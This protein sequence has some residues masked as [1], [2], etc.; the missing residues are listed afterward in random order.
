M[1]NN[2]VTELNHLTHKLYRKSIE[3]E[4]IDKVGPSHNPKIK[5][6]ISFPW[7]QIAFVGKGNNKHDAKQKAAKKALKYLK[8][9]GHE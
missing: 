5:M 1:K 3:I 8:E 9:K 4:M 2:L 7:E 6:Q